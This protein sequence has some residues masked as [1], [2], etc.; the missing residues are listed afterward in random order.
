MDSLIRD[1]GYINATMLCK[2]GGKLFGHYKTTKRTN[3]YLEALSLHLKIPIKELVL[4]KQGGNNKYEQGTWIHPYIATH[5]GQWISADFSIKVSIWIDEW[6]KTKEQNNIKYLDEL[7]NIKNDNA[8][9][10]KEK[11]YK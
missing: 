7:Q 3:T 6:K 11:K 9:N 1:D 10:C 5:L 2:A 4:S 8:N